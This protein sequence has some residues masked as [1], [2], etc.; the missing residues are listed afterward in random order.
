VGRFL[1]IDALIAVASLGAWYFWFAGFNR[2]RGTWAL[3]WVANACA[4]RAR[5]IDAEWLG[6]GLLR[7]R[8]RFPA[9]WFENA[10]VTVR[11]L[12]R[13]L[14]LHWLLC[15]WRKQKETLT[16]EADLDYAPGFQLNVIRHRWVTGSKK[17]LF[18]SA[19]REWMLS[20]PG[21]IVLTTQ[22]QWTHELTPLVNSL[23][24]A[25]GHNLISVRFRPQSPHF[26]ASVPL[27]ALAD[28]D[29]ANGFLGVLRELAAG[30]S[31]QQT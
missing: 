18:K 14:P 22:A 11:L 6:S 8:L 5:I 27:D 25:R 20:R 2:R 26:A 15:R 13:P 30:A 24:T 3:R 23:M 21:P 4:G 28:Q 31:T 10:I 7:A 9:H 1:V 16:F 19:K 17:P 12:P 29:V